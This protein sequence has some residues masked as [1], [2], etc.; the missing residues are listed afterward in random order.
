M[1]A[2]SP[3]SLGVLKEEKAKGVSH[4]MKRE[5]ASARGKGRTISLVKVRAGRGCIGTLLLKICHS[6]RNRGYG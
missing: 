2:V 5:E 3:D 1:H 4:V 6:F